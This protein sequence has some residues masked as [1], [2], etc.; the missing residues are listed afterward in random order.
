M[1]KDKI[2]DRVDILSKYK[3]EYLSKLNVKV[4]DGIFGFELKNYDYFIT[5]LIHDISNQI[6]AI[7]KFE[8]QYKTYFLLWRDNQYR[9]KIWEIMSKK[10]LNYD[11]MMLQLEEQ[12][13]IDEYVQK[14]CFKRR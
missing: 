11:F 6:E 5:S 2:Q 8:K 13:Q 1:N 3:E 9:L 7:K 12:N 10:L 14:S 4:S